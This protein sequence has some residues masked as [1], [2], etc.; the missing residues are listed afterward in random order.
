MQAVRP[1]TREEYALFFEKVR[2]WELLHLGREAVGEHEMDW[3]LTSLFDEWFLEGHTYAMASKCIAATCFFRPHFGRGAGC[4]LSGARQALRGWRRV[5][6]AASRLPLP[7][8]V[9][10][11]IANRLYALRFWEEA[12]IVLLCFFTYFRPSEPF[13]LRA[14]DVIPP[15]LGAGPGHELWALTLHPLEVGEP[16]KT[17]EYDESILLDHPSSH[18]LGPL[19]HTLGRQRRPDD[20]LFATTQVTYAARFRQACLELRLEVLGMPT[21]YQLRHA[22]ATC[23][24]VAHRRTLLEIQRRGRWRSQLSVRRYEKGG[25]LNEQLAKLPPALR[26]HAVRCAA[27]IVEV[28]CSARSPLRLD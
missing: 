13:K 17:S 11:A 6:P 14:K 2:L 10:A 21:P 22:G 7:W 26:D 19:L 8:P 23:D 24:F 27:S 1:A 16:S 3:V 28:A 12:M 20:L 18:F 5:E 4:H 25:R 15:C 9:V